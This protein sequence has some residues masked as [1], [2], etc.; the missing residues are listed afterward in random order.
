MVEGICSLDN[1]LIEFYDYKIWVECTP[2]IGM[3]RALT[4][5]KAVNRDLW[6]QKWIP[7]TVKYIEEQKPAQK[8]D[9]IIS[10]KKIS[11]L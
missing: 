11:Q 5:D 7:E 9:L 3:E 1:Q 8:C 10:Y 2:E 6:E 4:R